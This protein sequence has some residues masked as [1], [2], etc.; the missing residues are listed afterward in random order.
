MSDSAA[1]DAWRP[2]FLEWRDFA[3]PLLKAGKPKDA[4]AKYPWFTAGDESPAP[5]ARLA[6]PASE[7]RFGLITTGGYSIEG[8]QEPVGTAPR[9][10]DAMPEIRLIPLDVDRTKLRIDHFGYD[11]RFAK[12]DINVNLPLDR[13]KELEASGEIGSIADTTQV[14]MGLQPN[15]EP[16]IRD[17]VPELVNRFRSDS[18]EAALLVPS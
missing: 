1:L 6:K 18:V 11:H 13:L 8:E 3:L 14:L 7:T 9:M 17:L 4:F 16:L 5:F 2:R 12:E 10:D 15:V